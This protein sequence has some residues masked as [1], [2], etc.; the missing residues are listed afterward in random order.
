MFIKDTVAK[1]IACIAWLKKIDWNNAS[2]L[3][4]FIPAIVKAHFDE[5]E[6]LGLIR[7]VGVP[8]KANKD[9][10]IQAVFIDKLRCF[11]NYGYEIF[12]I[13]ATS[14]PR[15]PGECLIGVGKDGVR[16]IVPKTRV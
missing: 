5:R 1:A 14:D 3:S 9:T 12:R 15:C 4:K 13:S 6:L 11:Q 16:L 8:L 10:D 7:A 2:I